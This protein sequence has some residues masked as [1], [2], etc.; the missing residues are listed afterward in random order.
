[1][2]ERHYERTGSRR[3]EELLGD[4]EETLP[5][6]RKIAP[7]VVPRQDDPMSGVRRHLRSLEEEVGLVNGT[8]PVKAHNVP[9]E[10]SLTTP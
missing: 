7:R 6:F 5:K 9:T 2:I 10:P 4:W 1:M 8:A 3:A